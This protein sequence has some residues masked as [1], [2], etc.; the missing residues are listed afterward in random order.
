LEG[1]RVFVYLR[2]GYFK[3]GRDL[4]SNVDV[5]PVVVKVQCL[6][7]E[8]EGACKVEH[9][10]LLLQLHEVGVLAWLVLPLLDIC[11]RAGVLLV[12]YGVQRVLVELTTFRALIK[13][14]GHKQSIL[15]RPVCEGV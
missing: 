5:D 6:N 1:T 12:L 2:E 3:R 8:I 7:F 13:L 10:A 15:R 4:I 9:I 14:F 11:A